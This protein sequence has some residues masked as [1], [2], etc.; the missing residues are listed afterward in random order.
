[1]TS[2]WP[3]YKT[4]AGASSSKG[5]AKAKVPPPKKER[6]Q[7]YMNVEITQALYDQNTSVG[8]R[9]VHLP[10]GW[11][12]NARRVLVPLVPRHGRARHD[13]IR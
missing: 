3:F 8:L 12:L 13:E 9:D 7:Q 11:H 5:K 10:G 1:M 4:D 6:I 2:H